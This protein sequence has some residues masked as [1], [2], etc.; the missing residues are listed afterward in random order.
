[1]RKQV[2]PYDFLPIPSKFPGKNRKI[3]PVFSHSAY[4]YISISGFW[5][6]FSGPN[7]FTLL[8]VNHIRFLGRREGILI[9]GLCKISPCI[10]LLV[11]DQ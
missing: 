6:E 5:A 2:L 7:K 8:P 9:S 4:L 1:M 11:T 3:Y 10:I